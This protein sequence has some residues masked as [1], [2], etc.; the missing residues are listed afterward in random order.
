MLTTNRADYVQLLTHLFQPEEDDRVPEELQRHIF[1]EFVKVVFS[2]F[3]NHLSSTD[4]L[5]ELARLVSGELWTACRGLIADGTL[6]DFQFRYGAGIHAQVYP[7]QVTTGT[8]RASQ[9]TSKLTWSKNKS[10]S[11]H[12]CRLDLSL[13]PRLNRRAATRSKM[14]LP[15]LPRARSKKTRFLRLF[16]SAYLLLSFSLL[17]T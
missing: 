13:C 14:S 7:L 9:H 4:T 6:Y 11:V 2:T 15:H 3:E 1:P 17:P 5:Q 16:D 10:N 8:C 12:W